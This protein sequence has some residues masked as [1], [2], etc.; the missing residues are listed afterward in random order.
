MSSAYPKL[1]INLVV[2]YITVSVLRIWKNVSSW[3]YDTRVCKKNGSDDYARPLG[4][5]KGGAVC[6]KALLPRD[7]GF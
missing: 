7:S 5:Y 6:L 2:F 3:R 1:F 4:A